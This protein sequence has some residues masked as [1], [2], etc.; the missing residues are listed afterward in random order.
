[1]GLKRLS[2][3]QRAAIAAYKALLRL[4]LKKRSSAYFEASNCSSF[5]VM[6][7]LYSTKLQGGGYFHYTTV[8]QSV[9]VLALAVRQRSQAKKRQQ[10]ELRRAELSKLYKA[11][12][13]THGF[14]G[15]A[16]SPFASESLLSLRLQ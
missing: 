5:V 2:E 14:E 3:G 7:V 11:Y 8:L 10:P 15:G 4:G 9:E 12:T 16:L 6:K 13:L 1:M